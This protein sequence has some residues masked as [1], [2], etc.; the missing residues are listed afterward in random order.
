M[1]VYI[2]FQFLTSF[3]K[4]PLFEKDQLICTLPFQAIPFKMINLFIY[5][6]KNNLTLRNNAELTCAFMKKIF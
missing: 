5:V 2:Y 3:S 4:F 1:G 6:F